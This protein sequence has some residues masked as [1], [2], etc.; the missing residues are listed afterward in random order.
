[1]YWPF[2]IAYDTQLN[3]HA[4][5]LEK[6]KTLLILKYQK[7]AY[8]TPMSNKHKPKT[9]EIQISVFQAEKNQVPIKISVGKTMKR[10]NQGGGKKGEQR[11]GGGQA[12]K[13]YVIQSSLFN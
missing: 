5:I 10:A 4:L 8:N 1:M 11:E 13:K 9:K 7:L 12:G 6:K 2:L 3:P